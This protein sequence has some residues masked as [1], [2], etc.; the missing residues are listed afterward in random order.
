MRYFDK[1]N[2]KGGIVK[3]E[4][5]KITCMYFLFI[6]KRDNSSWYKNRIFF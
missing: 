6:E 4:P 1:H 2:I 5:T 3:I